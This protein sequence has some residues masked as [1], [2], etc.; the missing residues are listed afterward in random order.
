MSTRTFIARY[1]NWNPITVKIDS[2]KLQHE[3]G[4]G[5]VRHVIGTAFQEHLKG[6]WADAPNRKVVIDKDNPGVWSGRRIKDQ[7]KDKK[8]E[9][10]YVME[11]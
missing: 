6:Y 2:K 10:F 7:E 8:D 5:I 3:N 4:E 1:A 9:P 11:V